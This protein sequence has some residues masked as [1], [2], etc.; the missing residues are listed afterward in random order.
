VLRG[1]RGAPNNGRQRARFG[2][3]FIMARACWCGTRLDEHPHAGRPRKYCCKAHKPKPK[4]VAKAPRTRPNTTCWCGVELIHEPG[5]GRLRKYC[6]PSH[7]KQQRTPYKPDKPRPEKSREPIQKQIMTCR[8]CDKTFTASPRTHI[9]GAC[10]RTYWLNRREYDSL[11]TIRGEVCAICYRP[12]TQIGPLGDLRKLSVDHCHETGAIRELLCAKCNQ[13]LGLAD[14]KPEILRRA[15]KYITKHQAAHTTTTAATNQA[16]FPTRDTPPRL[17]ITQ[18]GQQIIDWRSEGITFKEIG[19]RFG[20]TRQRATQLWEQALSAPPQ[21]C[22]CGVEIKQKVR[23]GRPQQYC[24]PAHSPH[25]SKLITQ[26]EY[27]QL[28]AEQNNLCAICDKPE[29]QGNLTCLTVDHCHTSGL[30][31]ELLCGKCNRLLGFANDD[32]I[33]LSNATLYLKNHREKIQGNI[34]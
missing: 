4:P 21:K 23:A 25:R 29:T 33:A 30:I 15:A 8:L 19:R 26:G 28:A 5:P 3:I 20:V 13:I 34:A 14:D 12:E 10:S 22:W 16:R 24:T 17:G 1:T 27:N 7:G 2:T 9:C 11:A 31:R 6:K 32:L 18:R